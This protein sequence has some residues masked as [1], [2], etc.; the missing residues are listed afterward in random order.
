ML[1]L[2]KVPMISLFGP[3]DSEKFAPSYINSLV[4]DSK[5]LYNSENVN[6][7]TVE[8][9]LQ[10][11]KHHFVGGTIFDFLTIVYVITFLFS[12]LKNI[13]L[14]NVGYSSYTSNL[15]SATLEI[16]YKAP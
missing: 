7:I 10:V 3:T 13:F 9:V 4:L 12:Y 8:D 14:Y 11:A 6:S 1:G 2:S 5:K 15:F 16:I